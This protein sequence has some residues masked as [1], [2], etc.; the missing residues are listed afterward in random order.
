[1]ELANKITRQGVPI[2]VLDDGAPRDPRD[3]INAGHLNDRGAQRYSA[4][5]GEKL[6]ALW[7]PADKVLR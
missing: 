2:L 1:L 6:A 4:L 5:L 3:F 7:N